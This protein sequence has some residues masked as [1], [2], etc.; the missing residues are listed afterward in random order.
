M[1]RNNRVLS[2][3]EIMIECPVCEGRAI[4]TDGKGRS[5]CVVCNPRYPT[6]EQRLRDT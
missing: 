5:Y 1:S 3:V 2:M 6:R 4:V